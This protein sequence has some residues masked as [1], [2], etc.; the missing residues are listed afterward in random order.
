MAKG[1]KRTTNGNGKKALSVV[2]SVVSTFVDVDG[3]AVDRDDDQ[4][5]YDAYF[6]QYVDQ[7]EE[8]ETA[9]E[10]DVSAV[11]DAVRSVEGDGGN[12][13]IN[14]QRLDAIANLAPAE[15]PETEDK[16]D[17]ARNDARA[18]GASLP[19]EIG[20]LLRVTQDKAEDVAGAPLMV[21][22]KIDSDPKWRAL[23]DSL[24]RPG[25]KWNA[26]LGSKFHPGNAEPD[27]YRREGNIVGSVYQDVWDGTDEGKEMN[28]VRAIIKRAAGNK[29]LPGDEQA[30]SKLGDREL[31]Y[32]R[33][34]DE[35]D[36]EA[37]KKRWDG[38]RRK[39][40][41]RLRTAENFRR[42][43]HQIQELSK[44]GAEYHV[45]FVGSIET[46][47][48]KT[49]PIKIQLAERGKPADTSKAQTLT[50]FN[51]IDLVKA[52]RKADSEKRLV[53]PQD[54]LATTKRPGKAPQ[55]SAAEGGGVP[56]QPTWRQVTMM[57]RA[58]LGFMETNSDGRAKLA[59]HFNSAEGEGDMFAM[60]RMQAVAGGWFSDWEGRFDA[61]SR[62]REIKEKQKAQAQQP[63]AQK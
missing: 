54:M 60:G 44:E 21:A 39:S 62:Q 34:Y 15:L 18:I 45:F 53:T 8:G 36:N 32:K 56:P 63:Q 37:V 7:L 50:T 35:H 22:M 3:N 13:A 16:T 26:A 9:I 40:A 28:E 61:L 20:K 2:H 55:L 6:P 24:P 12:E 38:R 51:R 48:A 41:G 27:S 23:M 14:Q 58:I 59:E 30:W 1:T 43:R 5:I 57:A 46:A 33:L 11:A 19:K 47:A 4:A 31:E 10:A 42:L 29:A 17:K 52:K 25:T 49:N